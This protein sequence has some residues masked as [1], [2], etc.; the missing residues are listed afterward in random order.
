MFH[1][2]KS[3]NIFALLY[4]SG[5]IFV[6]WHK[7]KDFKEQPESNFTQLK[8]Q[9]LYFGTY[10]LKEVGIGIITFKILNRQSQNNSKSFKAS[11]RI[12]A[13]KIQ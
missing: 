1:K 10:V 13:R 11:Y 5:G 2:T 6:K 12:E 3:R 4:F 7:A 8:Q 9:R